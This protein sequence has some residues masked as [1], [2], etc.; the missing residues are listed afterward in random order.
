MTYLRVRGGVYQPLIPG[1]N[2]SQA[3]K[4]MGKKIRPVVWLKSKAL[5]FTALL[6]KNDPKTQPTWEAWPTRP[7]TPH[8]T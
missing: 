5:L 6:A 2:Y 3:Y 8:A 7:K 4:P 1:D